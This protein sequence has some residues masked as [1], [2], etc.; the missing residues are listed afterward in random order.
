MDTH[1]KR[2]GK[3]NG[4]PGAKTR[5][6][7]EEGT[8][9]EKNK[10]VGARFAGAREGLCVEWQPLFSR[11]RS[12]ATKGPVLTQLNNF[13]GIGSILGAMVG[14]GT[15]GGGNPPMACPGNREKNGA[16]RLSVARGWGGIE[17]GIFQNLG[18]RAQQP[19]MGSTLGGPKNIRT[20][21]VP[22]GQEFY[23][24]R[25]VIRARASGGG[26][27]KNRATWF[28]GG[29]WEPCHGVPEAEQFTAIVGTTRPMA[30]AGSLDRGR[31]G[32][33]P[34]GPRSNITIVIMVVLGPRAKLVF[35]WHGGGTKD[36]RGQ[37]PFKG[38]TVHFGSNQQPIGKNLNPVTF[39]VLC[40]S[41]HAYSSRTSQR[42]GKRVDGFNKQPGPPMGPGAPAR[43]MWPMAREGHTMAPGF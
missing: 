36:G 40:S 10:A 9:E 4:S 12:H 2:D 41:S 21:F 17:G 31:P 32:G 18:C 14:G 42:R 20:D 13:R 30:R 16:G 29:P 26:S 38:G 23:S 22:A 1:G 6:S 28:S 5:E 34:R 24:G 39:N 43:P 8:S 25:S 27:V 3:K 35:P 7:R 37:M 15:W 11:R 19:G 33:R